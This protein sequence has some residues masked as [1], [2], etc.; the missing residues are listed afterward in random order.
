MAKSND[1]L[2]APIEHQRNKKSIQ[3]PGLC[4]HSGIAN[5]NT[6]LPKP[7]KFCARLV[8]GIA[9]IDV[10]EFVRSACF[11]GSVLMLLNH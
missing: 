8:G 4:L 6:P 7:E 5:W 11:L 2:L 9:G 1:S 10:A 3:N